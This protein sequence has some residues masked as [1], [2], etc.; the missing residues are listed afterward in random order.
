[1]QYKV[2]YVHKQNKVARLNHLIV[3]CN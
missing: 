2:F 1:V 3:V